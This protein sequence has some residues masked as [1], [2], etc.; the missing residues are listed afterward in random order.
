MPRTV[1]LRELLLGV[2]GLAL[3]RQLYDGSD[4]EASARLDEIRQILDDDALA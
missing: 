2:E 1:A 3:L 4:A